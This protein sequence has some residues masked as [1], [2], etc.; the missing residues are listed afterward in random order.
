MRLDCNVLTL[1]DRAAAIGPGVHPAVGVESTQLSS[2]TLRDRTLSVAAGLQ[3]RGVRP[4]HQFAVLLDTRLESIELFF[5]SARLG[6]VC[7]PI[8][9]IPTGPVISH[10][11]RDG[12]RDVYNVAALLVEHKIT[13]SMVGSEHRAG[14]GDP[15]RS[16]RASEPK[17]AGVDCHMHRRRVSRRARRVCESHACGARP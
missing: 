11:C 1:L 7:V 17:P 2:V 3:R 5:A 9:P 12:D 14:V 16:T 13:H 8:S 4:G 6:A 15:D 10:V